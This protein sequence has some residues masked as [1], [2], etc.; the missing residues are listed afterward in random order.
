MSFLL[1]S[2]MSKISKQDHTQPTTHAR[3][4]QS[5]LDD[6]YRR[7]QRITSGRIGNG[8]G[9]HLFFAGIFAVDNQRTL[10]NVLVPVVVAAVL[11]LVAVVSC[12]GLLGLFPL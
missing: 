8:F 3:A 6:F 11:V 12:V 1:A 2:K 5:Y 10:F 4:H 7:D 9:S